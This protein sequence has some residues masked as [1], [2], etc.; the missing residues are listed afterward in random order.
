MLI[1]ALLGVGVGFLALLAAVM[2]AGAGHGSYLAARALFPVPMLTSL[3][4]GDTIGPVSL[5]LALAQ[6]PALGIVF[7]YCQ[8]CDNRL[9]IYVIIAIQ[10]LA[11]LAAFSGTIPNFS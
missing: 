4:E 6:F 2:S 5:S 11:A 3:V 8:A 7:G 9:P 10:L 1:G